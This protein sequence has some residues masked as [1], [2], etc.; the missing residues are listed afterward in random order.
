VELANTDA[1]RDRKNLDGPILTAD[2]PGLIA[3]IKTDR[4]PPEYR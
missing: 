2:L 1:V 3:A 4:F